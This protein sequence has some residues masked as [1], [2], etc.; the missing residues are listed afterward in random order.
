M[1][2]LPTEKEMSVSK[3]NIFS[4]IQILLL[5]ALVFIQSKAYALIEVPILK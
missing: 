1:T 5:H 2:N 4:G 3:E